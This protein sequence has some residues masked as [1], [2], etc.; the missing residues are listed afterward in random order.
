MMFKEFDRS[1][2]KN[3]LKKKKNTKNNILLNYIQTK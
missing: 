1:K 3:A 2:T